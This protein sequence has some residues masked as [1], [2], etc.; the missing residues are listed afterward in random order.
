MML[1]NGVRIETC[2]ILL[3]PWLQVGWNVFDFI[4]ITGSIL[5]LVLIVNVGLS[6]LSVFALVSV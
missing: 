4:I 3:L 2:V 5:D 1:I 6:I